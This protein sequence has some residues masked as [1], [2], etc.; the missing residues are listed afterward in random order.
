MTD[1]EVSA[2]CQY[3]NEA[4]LKVFELATCSRC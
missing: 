1:A 4:S 3:S 2:E